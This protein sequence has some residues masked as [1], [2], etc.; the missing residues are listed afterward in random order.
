M[1]NR[2][3]IVRRSG[4]V[5]KQQKSTTDRRVSPLRHVNVNKLLTPM[6]SNRS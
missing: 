3:I 5:L 6:S 4:P 2:N 1:A